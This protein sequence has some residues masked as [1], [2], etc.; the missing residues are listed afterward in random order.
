MSNQIIAQNAGWP[1]QFRFA[2]HGFWSGVCEFWR[3]A[4]FASNEDH[5]TSDSVVVPRRLSFRFVPTSRGI[6]CFRYSLRLIY[7]ES[8]VI[9]GLNGA[10]IPADFVEAHRFSASISANRF[11]RLFNGASLFGFNT[12]R[13][14]ETASGMVLTA[15]GRIAPLAFAWP[16]P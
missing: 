13:K 9:L 5:S 1:S 11:S 15:F 2:V 8:F 12:W 4:D 7:R 14:Y 16:P 6:E 10:Q 3:Q